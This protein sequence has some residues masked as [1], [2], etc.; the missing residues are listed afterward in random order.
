[1]SSRTSGSPPENTRLLKS[2]TSV[3]RSITRVFPSSVVSSS[4]VPFSSPL[5]WQCSH[6]RLHL[7]VTSQTGWTG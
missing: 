2:E 6:V 1:M 4:G 3:S 5:A 7:D